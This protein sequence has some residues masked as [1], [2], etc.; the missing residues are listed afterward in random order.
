MAFASTGW[1]DP[2]L[3][4]QAL[5]AAHFDELEVIGR[6][7]TDELVRLVAKFEQERALSIA[8]HEIARECL[9]RAGAVGDAFAGHSEGLA[10][11][12]RRKPS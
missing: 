1:R 6:R 8:R 4:E 10:P 11:N 9:W 3:Q 2:Q 5:E 12:R 7:H